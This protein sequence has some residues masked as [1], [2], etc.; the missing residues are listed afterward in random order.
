MFLT[1]TDTVLLVF[2]NALPNEI[3]FLQILP[4]KIPTFKEK[5]PISNAISGMKELK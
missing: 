4:E 3:L 1:Y 2:F 5:W